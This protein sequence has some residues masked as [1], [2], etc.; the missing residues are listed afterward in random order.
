MTDVPSKFVIFR[1]PL[2]LSTCIALSIQNHIKESNGANVSDLKFF[3]R[4]KHLT[5]TE[6]EVQLSWKGFNNNMN[7]NATT[8]TCENVVVEIETTSQ[9]ISHHK[10]H[11]Y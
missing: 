6:K 5:E 3:D 1:K 9:D 8:K 11:K 7:F 10:E 2:L 4:F